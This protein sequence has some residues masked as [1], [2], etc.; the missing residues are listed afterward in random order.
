MNHLFF[1]TSSSALSNETHS[2]MTK[3][4][5]LVDQ[6]VGCGHSWDRDSGRVSSELLKMP[7]GFRFVLNSNTCTQEMTNVIKLMY[8]HPWP[9]YKKISIETRERWF[10]KWVLHFIWDAE[11]NLTIRKIFDH[12]IGQR[13][14]QMLEDS[15]PLDREAIL[16]ETFKYTHT[17]KENKARFAN[18]WSQDNYLSKHTYD[19]LQ[20]GEDV[21]DGS[22][23]SAVD[24]DPVWRETTSAPYKN[25][26]Y[27][28]G[29]FFVSSLRISMLRPSLGSATSRAVEPEQ[30]VDLR[31]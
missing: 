17:L 14:Q 5:G 8:D 16:A 2:D 22:A 24:L 26:V 19:L 28:L 3:G 1:V 25:H 15:K 6:A 31:L 7:G 13:L 21:V 18:Q 23:A 29:S 11:H 4:R 30:G 9:S 20:S 27:G 12:R 10:Q